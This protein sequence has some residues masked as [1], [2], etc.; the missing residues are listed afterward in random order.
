[1]NNPFAN[2]DIPI[3]DEVIP[4][5]HFINYISN[6]NVIYH[7]STTL[8]YTSINDTIISIN[9]GDIF[10]YKF[11]ENNLVDKNGYEFY[12]YINIE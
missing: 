11:K 3:A 5:V 2:L 4:S 1:M 12:K 7:K 6:N 10:K 9:D 8:D